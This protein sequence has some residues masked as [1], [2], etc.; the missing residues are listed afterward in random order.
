VK[1]RFTELQDPKKHQTILNGLGD[2]GINFQDISPLISWF[3]I[4]FDKVHCTLTCA[5]TDMYAHV[6]TDEH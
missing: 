1:N 5:C 4:F 2:L 6:R 3:F